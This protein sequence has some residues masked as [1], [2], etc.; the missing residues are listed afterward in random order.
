MTRWRW[1]ILLAAV[2]SYGCAHG[3]PKSDLRPP[4]PDRFRVEAT[5]WAPEVPRSLALA[6]ILRGDHGEGMATPIGPDTMLTVGH[7]ADS[8]VLD[9]VD[10]RGRKGTAR[11]I[12]RWQG[13][14]LAVLQATCEEA[15]AVV[16]ADR[17][18]ASVGCP[19]LCFTEFFE[20]AP[21]PQ[22]GEVV[23]ALVLGAPVQGHVMGVDGDGDLGLDML[24]SRGSSGGPVVDAQGR[25]VGLVRASGNPALGRWSPDPGQ[26][27]QAGLEFLSHAVKFR[28]LG[29]AVPVRKREP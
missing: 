2:L 1:L 16:V 24:V 29:Y 8:A 15:M 6:V 23:W 4:L 19:V 21:A 22:Q 12:Q 11:P 7:L 20:P 26:D 17:T 14:T 10:A 18:G 28:A 9:W 5:R 25:L 13:D 27:P 3:R